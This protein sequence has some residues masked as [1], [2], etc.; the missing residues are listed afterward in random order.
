MIFYQ[1]VALKGILALSFV[2]FATSSMAKALESQP[3]E[4]AQG[5]YAGQNIEKV[6]LEAALSEIRPNTVIL[7]GENHGFAEHQRQHL[8]I[9]NQLRKQGLRVSVG[10]EFL[11]YLDQQ[12]IDLYRS[13]EISEAEFLKQ[14][15]WGDISFD[16]YKSQLLFPNINQGEFSLGLNMSREIT[17]KVMRGGLASLTDEEKR[18]YPPNFE[19]GRE[20]YRQR[21]AETIP[22]KIPPEMLN[23]WF[24]AQSTW[25]D[26]VAWV[27]SEFMKAHPEQVLVVVMG[28]FHVVYGGG[29][30]DRL[31]KRWPEGKIITFSQLNSLDL[32]QEEIMEGLKPNPTYGV[33]ADY[34]WVADAQPPAKK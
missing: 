26:T 4:R 1:N 3:I 24:S 9:L 28:D 34:V 25:D 5:L 16:F 6:S 11:N 2:I 21:F 23:N 18:F 8:E 7:I 33:R 20:I 22:H 29:L 12:K 31:H 19:L 15:K 10:L 14:V 30:P 17:N 32:N 13:G 27:S